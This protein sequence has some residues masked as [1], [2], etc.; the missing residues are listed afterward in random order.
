MCAR[1]SIRLA[2]FAGTCQILVSFFVCLLFATI[3]YVMVNR[4]YQLTID[5]LAPFPPGISY[6]GN[7]GQ[8][9]SN[10]D[11][12]QKKTF[13]LMIHVDAPKVAP[14]TFAIFSN[15]ESY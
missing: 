15:T 9:G 5:N 10:E 12:N 13:K 2:C 1:A 11:R 6:P 7:S 4:Y 14:K 8:N 3:L